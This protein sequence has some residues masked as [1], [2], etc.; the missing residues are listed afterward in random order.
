M[1]H[2]ISAGAN[3]TNKKNRNVHLDMTPMVDLAFLLVTFFVL[4]TSMKKPSVMEII[5]PNENGEPN[6]VNNAIT[7]LLPAE[8]ANCMYYQGKWNGK[9]TVL[10]PTDFSANGLRKVLLLQNNST[11]FKLT[12]LLSSFPLDKATWSE[13]QKALYLTNYKSIMEATD[14]PTVLIKTIPTTPFRSVV[15]ALDEMNI[16]S[17]QKRVVQD[18]NE[19]ER[20]L[21]EQQ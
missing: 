21:F 19:E 15:S 4:A 16:C 8:S 17:I 18:M 20:Q 7:L 13:Q 5:Y 2:I 6:E 11:R 10:T 12:E 14:A 3:A 1:A 9:E